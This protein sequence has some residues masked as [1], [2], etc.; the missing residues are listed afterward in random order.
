MKTKSLVAL[1][2]AG[3]MTAGICST[4]LA[5][6]GEKS[7]FEIAAAEAKYKSGIFKPA[8]SRIETTYG[9]LEFPDG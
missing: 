5:Q 6:T 7:I 2:L 8:P 9:N 1:A 3:L 4:A